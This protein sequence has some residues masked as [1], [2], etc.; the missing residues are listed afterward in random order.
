MC[1]GLEAITD[2]VWA[3]GFT[4]KGSVPHVWGDLRSVLFTIATSHGLMQG[5]GIEQHGVMESLNK[6]V[7]LKWNI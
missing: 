7:D 3:V 4:F 2:L 1:R 6:H 5:D